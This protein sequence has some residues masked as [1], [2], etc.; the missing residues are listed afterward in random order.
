VRRA[1]VPALGAADPEFL[2][3][4]GDRPPPVLGDPLQFEPLVLSMLGNRAG[5]KIE[6]TNDKEW[7]ELVILAEGG[8]ALSLD[9]KDMTHRTIAAIAALRVAHARHPKYNRLAVWR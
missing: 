7:N 6:A 5:A 1:F 2:I 9:Q 3:D 8:T 4:L